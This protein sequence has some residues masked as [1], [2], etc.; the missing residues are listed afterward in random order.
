MKDGH[1]CPSFFW[2]NHPLGVQIMILRL[3][4]RRALL[5]VLAIVAMF[6]DPLFSGPL[7]AQQAAAP[8]VASAPV[9][10]ATPQEATVLKERARGLAK[11]GN[12]AQ[13]IKAY[14]TAVA[15]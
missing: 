4:S 2:L 8:P 1:S 15:A 5:A 13:A 12:Y 6:S 7:R 3:Q 14:D 11:Q 9:G 10:G